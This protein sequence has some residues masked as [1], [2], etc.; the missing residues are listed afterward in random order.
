MDQRENRVEITR[1][2]SKTITI[3][4]IRSKRIDSGKSKSKTASNNTGFKI[5]SS[6]SAWLLRLGNPSKQNLFVD[7]ENF[8]FK[9]SI[10]TA[11]GAKVPELIELAST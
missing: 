11:S 5:F 1:S 6:A 4:V 10:M 7:L 2:I 8:C 9:R 3:P